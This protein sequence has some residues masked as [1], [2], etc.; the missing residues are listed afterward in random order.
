MIDG[1]PCAELDGTRPNWPFEMGIVAYFGMA[2]AAFLI[3]GGMALWRFLH[4]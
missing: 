3:S 4:T 2:G 1:T